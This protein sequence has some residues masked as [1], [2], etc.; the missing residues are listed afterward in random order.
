MK[1]FI[2]VSLNKDETDYVI[3]AG[4][5]TEE[6]LKDFLSA[7]KRD[8]GEA[9]AKKLMVYQYRTDFNS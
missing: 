9:E 7:Y 1:A 8:H 3:V 4:D 5:N 2:V 6:E